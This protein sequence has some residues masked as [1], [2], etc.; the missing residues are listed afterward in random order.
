MMHDEKQP[1]AI[2]S[3]DLESNRCSTLNNLAK[4]AN[5]VYWKLGLT[6]LAAATVCLPNHNRTA[7]AIESN[8]A[9]AQNSVSQKNTSSFNRGQLKSRL[10]PQ[11][12]RSFSRSIKQT[13]L[14]QGNFPKNQPRTLIAS[15][16]DSK[17]ISAIDNRLVESQPRIHQV[18]AGD[19]INRI[20]KMYRVTKDEIV[21]LNQLTNSNVIFV[22]Q[23]LKIPVANSPDLAKVE[24]RSPVVV[25]SPQKTD[26]K[27]DE[28]NSENNS[29]KLAQLATT[30]AELNSEGSNTSASLPNSRIARLKAE[31]DLLRKQ[32]REES[33][34]IPSRLDAVDLP[35]ITNTEK[36]NTLPT[37]KVDPQIPNNPTSD[38]LEDAIALTLPP[39]PPSTEYLPRAFEGYIWPAQGV[40]TS[41]Y[42]WRWGRIHQGIDI[43]APIGTP[44]VAAASG[45]VINVGYQS[46]YGNLVKL[47]HLDGSVTVYA[48]NHR[49]LVTHGQ[50]VEQGE[51]IAE[52]GNTGHSTGPHVHFEIITKD[53]KAIDPLALLK[54]K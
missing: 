41:G 8:E 37:A 5:H 14:S 53:R 39:L 9:I 25:S 42:G 31:L 51:K 24:R 27:A 47:E 12:S 2:F 6:A 7:N 45:K 18:Q 10:L 50:W 34:P 26:N 30:S 33:P 1:P 38:L 20:A 19:T 11:V 17:V 3:S 29:V 36:P 35:P 13:N 44:I 21:K 48:H 32:Y 49:N 54:S 16:P 46:G 40:L 4:L 15:T 28:A 22:N 43:A 52:M 23:Q